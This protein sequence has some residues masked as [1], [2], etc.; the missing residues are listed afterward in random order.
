MAYGTL[1]YAIFIIVR[2]FICAIVGGKCYA[3]IDCH[4]CN[5]LDSWA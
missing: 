2:L 3:V 1:L 4:K 5:N